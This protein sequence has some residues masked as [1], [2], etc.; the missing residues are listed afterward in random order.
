MVHRR[1]RIASRAL[2]VSLAVALPRT[3]RAQ[4]EQSSSIAGIAIELRGCGGVDRVELEKLL[5][6]EFRTLNVM[7][8][9][10]S[11]RVVID[12]GDG[13]AALTFSP[14]GSSSNV[15]LSGTTPAAWPRLLALAVS[16]L[17]MEARARA[18]DRADVAQRSPVVFEPRRASAAPSV[19]TSRG[20]VRI[21]AGARG[22][23]IPGPSAVL[24]GPE[25]GLDVTPFA[26]VAFEVRA[27]GMFGG[28]DTE[29]AHVHWT[30]VG[31]TVAVRWD[32]RARTWRCGVGPGLSLDALRLSPDVTLRGATGHAV[33]GPWGG[34][35]L[36]VSA[37]VSL[38]KAVLA[39][40]RVDAG[41]LTFPL[42][43]D[44]SDG[45]RLVDASGGWIA[46][47]LGIGASL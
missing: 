32:V 34:P 8:Q 2:V 43:G 41:I 1:V 38:G 36:D 26:A 17:V 31:G 12:C 11:E 42:H 16:E 24:W 25:I 22:Q 23:W 33:V 35:E 14:S 6:I 18:P 10:T 13:N 4:A 15:E 40:V 39:Y 46:G 30:A 5:A 28:T 20:F 27:H 29:L 47:T 45:R 9:D 7:P 37:S 21:F 44:A 19:A 3:A